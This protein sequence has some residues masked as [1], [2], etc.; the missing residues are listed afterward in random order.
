MQNQPENPKV[1]KFAPK[2]PKEP[3]SEPLPSPHGT[4]GLPIQPHEPKEPPKAIP[5]RREQVRQIQFK[6]TDFI[7]PSDVQA[8][9]ILVTGQPKDINR[10][11]HMVDSLELHPAGV[12]VCEPGH[13]Y[14][15]PYAYPGL[16]IE[17]VP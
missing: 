4:H 15:I 13:R 5:V 7:T 8:Q 1:N 16:I 3:I 6:K 10:R 11:A 12:L 17:L 9:L 2:K 14:I